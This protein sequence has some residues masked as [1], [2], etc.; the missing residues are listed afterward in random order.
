MSRKT[1][2][3]IGAIIGSLLGGYLPTLFGADSI[4]FWSLI[5]SAVGGL[6]G[7]YVSFRLTS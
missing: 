7:I 6:I 4:S 2:I 3:I 5:G 1:A